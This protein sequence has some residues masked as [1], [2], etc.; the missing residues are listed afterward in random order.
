[1]PVRGRPGLRRRRLDAARVSPAADTNRLKENFR[2]AGHGSCPFA[3]S[4]MVPSLPQSV[5]A[6]ARRVSGAAGLRRRKSSQALLRAVKACEQTQRRSWCLAGP[7]TT[8]IST[9]GGKRSGTVLAPRRALPPARGIALRLDPCA[10]NQDSSS[11]ARIADPS[12]AVAATTTTTT[13]TAVATA[14]VAT[15]TRPPPSP[16]P[17]SPPPPPS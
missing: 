14:T 7:S 9:A 1:M 5:D 17:P 13:T 15:T 3:S 10:R 6:L 16:P 12:A 4:T 11:P 8:P 2:L